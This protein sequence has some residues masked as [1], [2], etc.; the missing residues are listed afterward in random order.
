MPELFLVIL[1]IFLA[2]VFDFGNGFNDAAN[3]I[4][5]VVA[6]RVLSLKAA[7]ILAAVCNLIA[8]FIFGVAVATTIAKGIIDSNAVNLWMI[9]SGLVGAI[10]WVWSTTLVGLPISASHALI[11]G[12]IGAA[13]IGSGLQSIIW[14]GLLKIIIFIF[15]APSVGFIVAL[16]FFCVVLA[17]VRH[18]RPERINKY[19]KRLQ[20]I[21]VSVYSLGHGTN[22]AQKT[23]GII[24]I[25]LF[26]AGLLGSTFYV[27]FWVVI[28]SHLTIALGTLAGGWRVVK[29]MGLQITK[30]RPIHGFCAET[31]GAGTIIACTILGI[32]VSTTHIISGAIIGV[33]VRQRLSAVRWVIARKILWAWLLTIPVSASIGGLIYWFI[34]TML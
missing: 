16:I 28:A 34:Q 18:A 4:S 17:L 2:L 11:G 24:A 23:M 32:P 26:T 33:G 29:T 5:T 19:F 14:S 8:A 10:I 25:T 21:S 3:S 22:D 7:V 9:M 1:I 12:F 6:T 31:S 30:L 15:V 20:L 27:P 13:I